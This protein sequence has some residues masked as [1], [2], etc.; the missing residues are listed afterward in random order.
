[1][2]T[3]SPTTALLGAHAD[4]LSSSGRR[5][6][7]NMEAEHLALRRRTKAAICEEFVAKL[8]KRGDVEVDAP[9]FSQ[10]VRRHFELLPSRYSLDV[11]LDSLDVLS[12]KR[13][14]DEA[15]ADPSAVSF[16]VRPVEIIVPRQAQRVDSSGLDSPASPTSGQVGGR[17]GEGG[18]PGQD[19]KSGRR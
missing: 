4:G 13:L 5:G 14:L 12:H 16:A 10:S 18:V 6:A 11:N 15:R 9:G 19:R 8:R 1:M 2:L 3:L 17:R 7:S